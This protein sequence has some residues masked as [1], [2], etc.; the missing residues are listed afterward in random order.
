MDASRDFIHKNHIFYQEYEIY[1]DL[2]S[3]NRI[4]ESSC[5]DLS[6]PDQ[7]PQFIEINLSGGMENGTLDCDDIYRIEKFDYFNSYLIMKTVVPSEDQPDC[8]Y[9]QIDLHQPIFDVEARVSKP[10]YYFFRY[11]RG[12]V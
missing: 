6:H 1:I 4:I 10:E 2:V 3:K 7:L 8:H 5:L 11:V 12:M 9:K